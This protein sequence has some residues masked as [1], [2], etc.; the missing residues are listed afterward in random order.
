MAG[1]VFTC[2]L[3][4]G[5]PYYRFNFDDSTQS[6]ESVTAG[7]SNDLRTIILSRFKPDALE[8][9]EPALLPV[10]KAVQELEHL[11]VFDRLDIEF[12]IDIAGTVH[13]FQVR[14]ITVDHSE[15]VFLI[16]RC[17]L[18]GGL[19]RKILIIP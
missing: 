17:Y 6:T 15:F 7:T 11:L 12:A 1:V 8:T 13:I 9:I 4:S 14:P 5:A 19:S 16:C 2:S 3:E 10:L 18:C